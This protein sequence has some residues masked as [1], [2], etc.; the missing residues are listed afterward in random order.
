MKLGRIGSVLLA[1]W[2]IVE[3]LVKLTDISIDGRI[4]A[5]LAVIAGIMILI[6][7]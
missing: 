6:G 7:K 4:L 5:V 1:V 3:G 2:L